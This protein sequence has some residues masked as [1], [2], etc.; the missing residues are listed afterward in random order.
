MNRTTVEPFYIIGLAIRTTNENGTSATDIPKLWERFFAE[1]SIVLIPNKTSNELYCMYT[2]Y[3]SDY[4]K[5]YTT[6]LGCKVSSLDE[7]P[8]GFTG[9]Q[10][11]GGNYSLITAKGKMADGIVFQEWTKIWNGD[12]P[13]A[14]TAD[15]EIYGDKAQNPDHAEVDIF[16]AVK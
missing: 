14:Y 11:D 9:K 8:E 16:V 10:V 2:D 5:P 3:E 13:R 4:T 12:L 6:I 15:F 1:N 7:I